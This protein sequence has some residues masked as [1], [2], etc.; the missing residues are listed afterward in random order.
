MKVW[1][2]LSFE[3]ILLLYKPSTY[4]VSDVISTMI[5]RQGIVSAQFSYSTA[6]GMFQSVVSMVFIVGANFLS[7][8]LVDVGLF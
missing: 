3:K 7:R 8:K 6:V 5:Y 1:R 2:T 4:V